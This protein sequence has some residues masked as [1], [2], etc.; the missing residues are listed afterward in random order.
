MTG[1]ELK[2]HRVAYK[3]HHHIWMLAQSQYR[4]ENIIPVFP[5]SLHSLVMTRPQTTIPVPGLDDF[6]SLVHS[7][8]SPH[9]PFNYYFRFPTS[10]IQTGHQLPI[11]PWPWNI[12]LYM[13]TLYKAVYTKH[14]YK[15]KTVPWVPPYHIKFKSK[16]L[17][18]ALRKTQ[19]SWLHV[20]AKQ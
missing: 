9:L 6:P 14:N 18:T 12:C 16:I 11:N 20:Q 4:I 19:S 3:C 7:I 5:H 13:S 15:Q 10:P 2:P 1:T 8:A 17:R